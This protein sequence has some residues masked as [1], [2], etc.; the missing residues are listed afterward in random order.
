MTLVNKEIFQQ[1]YI[2]VK[3]NAALPAYLSMEPKRLVKPLEDSVANPQTTV[4]AGLTALVLQLLGQGELLLVDLDGFL[5]VAEL[6]QH[7]PHVG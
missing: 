2:C 3:T 4:A 1:F 6:D 7:L 5:Q